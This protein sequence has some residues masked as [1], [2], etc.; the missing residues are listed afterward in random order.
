MN[1]DSVPGYLPLINHLSTFCYT[2]AN[3][4]LYSDNV[5]DEFYG[6]RTE[7]DVFL[8]GVEIKTPTI[9]SDEEINQRLFYRI[10]NL[11]YVLIFV[12]SLTNNIDPISCKQIIEYRGFE[13][14]Y[15]E[16]EI[17]YKQLPKEDVLVRNIDLKTGQIVEPDT[18]EI[19]F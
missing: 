18:N 5:M 9:E 4:T 2:R 8:C 10:V 19:Y 12:E 16:N 6:R 7:N 13:V 1:R 17:I 3:F 14:E 15:K 11:P